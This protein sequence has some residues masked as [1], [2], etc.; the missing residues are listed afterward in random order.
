MFPLIVHLYAQKLGKMAGLGTQIHEE[1]D[2]SNHHLHY[3]NISF[4]NIFCDDPKLRVKV[5]EIEN[6][7]TIENITTRNVSF[8]L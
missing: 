6:V 2:L 1:S 7:L 3:R 5:E 4:E 8:A